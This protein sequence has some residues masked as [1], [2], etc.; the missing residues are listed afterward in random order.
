MSIQ[1]RLEKLE[2]MPG[3]DGSCPHKWEV[4][5]YHGEREDAEAEAAND[6]RPSEVC[7]ECGLDRNRVSVLY[8]KQEPKKP[9]FA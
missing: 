5:T 8:V 7:G 6:T 2:Q 3:P 4:R 1:T 9:V